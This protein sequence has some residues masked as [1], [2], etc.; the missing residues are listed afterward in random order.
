MANGYVNA[1][2]V[3]NWSQV[4]GIQVSL[5]VSSVVPALGQDDTVCLGCSVFAGSNDRL[6]RA[7]FQTTIGIRN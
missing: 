6:V 2:E 5:L 3:A 7:E 4:V 1:G